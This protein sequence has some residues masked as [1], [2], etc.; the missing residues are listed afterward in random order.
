MHLSDIWIKVTNT[1][2]QLCKY[3]YT[4]CVC[5]TILDL[6]N[7]FGLIY[8]NFTSFHKIQIHFTHWGQCYMW[9]VVIEEFWSTCNFNSNESLLLHLMTFDLRETDGDIKM[10]LMCITILIT[11]SCVKFYGEYLLQTNMISCVF[12]SIILIL[13]CVFYDRKNSNFISMTCGAI[14][15]LMSIFPKL[16]YTVKEWFPKCGWR[17]LRGIAIKI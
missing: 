5:V 7:F 17:H 9:H 1:P 10:L 8:L 6:K 13:T 14:F 12:V 16:S 2:R 3:S 11:N 15:N 4:N